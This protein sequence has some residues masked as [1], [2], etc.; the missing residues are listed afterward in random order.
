M[1]TKRL[2]DDKNGI[3][4]AAKILKSGGIVAIPTETVYGLAASAF[5]DAAIEKIF[6][7]KGRPQ[8]NPLIV[9]ISDLS[10]IEQVAADFSGK[11]EELA[12]AFW[13]AALTLVLKK[14]KKIANSVSRGLD[15]VAVRMPNCEV[16]RQIINE[17]GIPLA[18]PSANISGSPSPTSYEHVIADLDGK[19]DAVVC[20]VS[21]E[22]G[23]ESTVVSL[24]SNPPRLL[25]PGGITPEQLLEYLPDLEI[26]KAV[27]EELEKGQK[28]AS[29]GMKYRHY[30]PK[31][32]VFLV[33]AEDEAFYNFVNSKKNAAAICFLEDEDNIIIKTLCYGKK[34]SDK[35]QAKALFSILR[36][37][38]GLGVGEVY[39]RAPEKKGIGLAVYNRLIRAA[40]F[41]VIRL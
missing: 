34:G 36:S 32:E 9:H 8:D 23:L 37:V 12:K 38:D 4:A 27:L 2:K 17:T 25:R 1:Q 13:P 26:D 6:A 11:A 40:G 24:V 7:A 3:V 31:T 10:M 21:S 22:I 15:T 33:E 30:S 18:A 28:A 14:G 39:V 41:K 19:I 29:P 35:E 20:S 5:D 16:A